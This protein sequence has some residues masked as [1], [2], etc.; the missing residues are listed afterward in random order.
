MPVVG[1][2][3]SSFVWH[4]QLACSHPLLHACTQLLEMKASWEATFAANMATHPWTIV[5][6]LLPIGL[7][8][9]QAAVGAPRERAGVGSTTSTSPRV[10]TY[11]VT[12][13]PASS[14][15]PAC[16]HTCHL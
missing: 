11:Q 10:L 9:H 4:A 16:M 12:C 8:L 2:M 6:P 13:P 5:F 7:M 3:V 1:S 14:Q 15:S